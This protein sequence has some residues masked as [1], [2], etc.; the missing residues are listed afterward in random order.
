MLFRFQGTCLTKAS[1]LPEICPGVGG[2]SAKLRLR[3]KG[4]RFTCSSLRGL[5]GT[6][7]PA[8][9]RKR[10]T[11]FEERWKGPKS[12]FFCPANHESRLELAFR[13]PFLGQ[14]FSDVVDEAGM[15]GSAKLVVLAGLP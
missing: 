7:K 15:G 1:R 9:V 11:A 13:M 14:R 6:V 3:A 10:I 8:T 2:R 5:A 12:P 4:K